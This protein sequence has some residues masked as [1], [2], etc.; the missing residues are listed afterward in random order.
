MNIG[1]RFPVSA[2]RGPRG[3]RSPVTLKGWS[4]ANWASTETE[5]KSVSCGVIQADGCVLYTF[6]RRQSVIA[7]SSAES[8]FYAMTATADE[9]IFFFTKLLGFMGFKVEATI[10][11]DSSAAKQIGLREGVGKIRHL[12]TRSLW[13]QQ[14]LK[15]GE[16]SVH[17]TPGPTNLADVG[18]KARTK[19]RLTLL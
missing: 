7:T 12:D 17:K 16:L 2:R 11:T 1:V 9:T 6:A 18:T 3:D 15:S 19:E 8:E 14:K 4:D 10:L 5:R 13:L